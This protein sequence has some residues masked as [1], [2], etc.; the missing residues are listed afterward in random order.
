MNRSIV[1]AACAAAL[2]GCNK[3]PEVHEKN[4]TVEEV[5]NAVAR[6]GVSDDLYL[7]AGAWQVTST[8][9]EMAIPGLSPAAQSEMKKVMGNRGNANYRF[10]LTPEQAKRPG[11]KFFSRQADKNCRYD[12]FTMGKG[13]IDAVMRC[14]APEGAMT[15]TVAGNYS[16]DSYSTQVAMDMGAREGAMKMKMRSEAHRVGDCTPK[17]LARAKAESGT[18]G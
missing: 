3:S 16:A 6:S 10:C 14:A 9:E 5:A 12:H 7:K 2:A 11:G 18:K 15:M 8:I 1:I 4:A 17:D 13:K